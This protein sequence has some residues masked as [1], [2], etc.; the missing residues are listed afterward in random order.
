MDGSQIIEDLE[1]Y[2]RHSGVTLSRVKW[3]SNGAQVRIIW[4]YVLNGFVLG[5]VRGACSSL[6]VSEALKG[7]GCI[8][9]TSIFSK[10]AK[11]LRKGRHSVTV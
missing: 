11:F 5:Q 8:S 1:A 4:H 7:R 6:L 3:G 9:C 10:V 2:Q